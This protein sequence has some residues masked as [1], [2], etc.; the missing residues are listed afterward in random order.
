MN[1]FEDSQKYFEAMKRLHGDGKH[2][3]QHSECSKLSLGQF[4]SEHIEAVKPPRKLP[5]GAKHET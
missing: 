3:C 1:N 2:I 4:C 5:T